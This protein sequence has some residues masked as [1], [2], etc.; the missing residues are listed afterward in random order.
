MMFLKSDKK[1]PNYRLY[2]DETKDE[3][4]SFF[5]IKRLEEIPEQSDRV[6]RPHRHLNLFQIIWITHGFG[7]IMVDEQMY[8]ME[9]GSLFYISPG[10]VHA[11]KI[12]NDFKGF[13]V[14][15]SPDLLLT[16]KGVCS[17][18]EEINKTINNTVLVVKTD[19][20]EEKVIHGIV[21]DIWKESIHEF[22]EKD[23]IIS[24]YLNIL[25]VHVLRQVYQDINI[26]NSGVNHTT[27]QNFRNLIDQYYKK[28]R[29]VSYYAS[30][31]HITPTYLNDTI[32]KSTGK[33]AGELI[34]ERI[35]L[36]AK[37]LLIFSS[38]SISEI[39]YE[40]GFEDSAYFWKFF[41]K[42]V[43]ISPK[44]FREKH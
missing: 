19:K 7:D 27:I 35:I 39:A 20:A 15:F 6:H 23:Q 42:Y 38:L 17:S 3:V 11:C 9:K 33:T 5:N 2:G 12:S 37:R 8:R 25:M 31:L 14:H 32:K 1:I 41:K 30:L 36:E 34:R 21:L 43:S 40:L 26:E 18:F 22:V 16:Q 24:N 10:V 44:L 29:G 13:V 28:E 4:A